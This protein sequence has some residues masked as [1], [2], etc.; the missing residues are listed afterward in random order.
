MVDSLIVALAMSSVLAVK[1][2]A[3][4]PAPKAKAPTHVVGSS[5]DT[6]L[7]SMVN[8]F[9]AESFKKEKK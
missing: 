4:K 5:T 8:Q 7:Q 6:L 9:I 3:P 1:G 2:E